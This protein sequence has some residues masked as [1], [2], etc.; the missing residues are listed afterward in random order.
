MQRIVPMH[1]FDILARPP[2][3]FPRIDREAKYF[4]RL[5]PDVTGAGFAGDKPP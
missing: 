4:H 1:F 2:R 5:S 3:R